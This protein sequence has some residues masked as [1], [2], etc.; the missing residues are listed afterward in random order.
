[1]GILATDWTFYLQNRDSFSAGWD[2]STKGIF[3]LYSCYHISK[4]SG[5]IMTHLVIHGSGDI[6]MSLATNHRFIIPS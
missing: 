5:S 3:H 6:Q 4:I 2:K 1:M